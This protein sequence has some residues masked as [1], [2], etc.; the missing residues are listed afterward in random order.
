LIEVFWLLSTAYLLAGRWPNGDPPAWST[1]QAVP[2]P[3]SAE[4]REQRMAARG[5]GRQ[6][7]QG[8]QAPQGRQS[9]K[10]NGRSPAPAATSTGTGTAAVKRKRKRRK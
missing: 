6:P 7:R 10:R 4:L 5:Q 1:G 3:S 2:W 8:R 9:P